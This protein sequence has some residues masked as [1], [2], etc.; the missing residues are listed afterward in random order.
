MKTFVVLNL[1]AVLIIFASCTKLSFEEAISPSFDF[2]T[3]GLI[4]FT[5]LGDSIGET[6]AVNISDKYPSVKTRNNT[7]I[8]LP[9]NGF[10]NRKGEGINGIIQLTIRQ[11]RR[12]SEMLLCDKPTQSFDSLSEGGILESFGEFFI[13]AS[14]NGEPLQLQE[15]AVV[16]LTTGIN[17]KSNP[18]K[19]PIWEADTS[20]TKTLKGLNH[21]AEHVT[22]ERVVHLQK[23]A[24]WQLNG[25]KATIN[26]DHQMQLDIPKLDMW[27]NCDVLRPLETDNLTTVLVYFNQNYIPSVNTTQASAVFFKPEG[28][29]GLLKFYNPILTDEVNKQGFYSYENSLPVGMRGKLLAFTYFEGHFFMDLKTI[30]ITAPTLGRN[31]MPLTVNPVE[32]SKADFMAAV[33]SLDN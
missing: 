30:E 27:F 17:N 31:F 1:L 20:V 23:G 21:N 7:M 28:F 3:K 16:T 15:G 10:K 5:R 4:D 11:C 14:Q 32:V 25:Q 9:I 26:K 8:S 2:S 12:P 13:S 22:L 24:A 19:I 29:N 33:E 6:F 18:Q